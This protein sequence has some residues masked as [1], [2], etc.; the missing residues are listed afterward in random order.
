M[1]LTACGGGSAP[2][3]DRAAAP[4]PLEVVLS[5]HR[6]QHTLD[7][8]IR[9]QQQRITRGPMRAP[10]LERL[11]WLFVTRAR[12]L[13]DPGAYQLTLQAALAIEALEPNH[14]GALLLRG[15]ALHSLHRFAEAEV[16]ARRL[17]AERGAP[18]DHGLLG[19]VLIDRGAL[20]QAIESYQTMMDQR[21]DQHAYTRAAH[22]RYLKGDLTGAL[23]AMQ[24]AARAASPRN[25]D[26]FAWT[27][28]KLAGYQL[29]SGDAA[30]ALSSVQRALE[31][32]PN[33]VHA[34]RARASIALAG[35]GA[36]LAD[37]LAPLQTA[38]A[39]TPHPDLLW[40]LQEV[41]ELLGR[42][43]EASA[44]ATQLRAAA[45]EDP[46]AFALYLAA[47]GQDLAQAE[48]LARA[49]LNVRPDVYS[50]EA[51][52]LV[53]SMQ[54]DHTRALEHATHSLSTD[55]ADPRLLYH[56]GVIA[57]RAGSMAQAHAWLGRAAL[58]DQCLLPSQRRDLGM[59]LRSAAL[60][61][62][63]TSSAL[64]AGPSSKKPKKPQEKP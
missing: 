34:L 47:H 52:A 43:E 1:L 55:A 57:Q 15:H 26:S 14:R 49:E 32:A 12:E 11:G 50:H 17:V 13:H 60:Q 40:M 2:A 23:T 6:G 38:V 61:L 41:L 51:L 48:R 24:V 28:A 22:V 31:V 8:Q 63:L 35:S 19:D 5:E 29:Q 59:R 56:A 58:Y 3:P 16:I 53:L 9:D 44:T 25:R 39:L 36:Q 62:H 4:S 42:N 33:S 7:A 37:A 21:P 45:S 64:A 46:R 54:G 20:D 18:F 27:W 30:A 10:D